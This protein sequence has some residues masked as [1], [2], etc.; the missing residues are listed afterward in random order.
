MDKIPSLVGVLLM[1]NNVYVASKGPPLS[2]FPDNPCDLTYSPPKAA[3]AQSKRH[4]RSSS[5]RPTKT[6]FINNQPRSTKG[7]PMLFQ[8]GLLYK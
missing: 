2:S 5:H 4:I 8:V 1:I 6:A 3:T 7:L